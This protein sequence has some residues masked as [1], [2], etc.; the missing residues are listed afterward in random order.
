MYDLLI[1]KRDETYLWLK[2]DEGIIYELNEYFSFFVP[3]FKFMPKYK[4]KLWDGRIRLLNIQ[5]NT[6]YVGLLNYLTEY[7][8]ENG[9][10][11]KVDP[12]L[13][14]KVCLP[15]DEANAFIDSLGMPF[16]M[17]DYQIGSFI[18]SIE[19]KRMLLLSPTGSGSLLS[20]I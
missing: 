10:S 12:K 4:N 17:R 9:Y 15:I 16:P 8:D 2:G 3:N 19:K 1:G 13:L 18:N 20:S 6:L 14:G 11:Y 5:N 7:C